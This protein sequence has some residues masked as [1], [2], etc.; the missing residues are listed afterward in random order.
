MDLKERGG[1][2]L[3]E[4]VIFAGIFT[5]T[6]AS[7]LTVLVAMTR[8]QVRQSGAAEV[9][10]QSQF[11]LQT[12]QRYVEQSSLVDL[13]K[14]SATTTL[15]LRMAS[16]SYDPTLI[17]ASGTALWIQE[18]AS[19]PQ[20]LTSPKVN[21]TNLSFVKHENPG[22]H[23]SVSVV[24]TANYNAPN[25]ASNFVQSLS[26]SVA[27][28]SAATFDSNIIP[29]AGNT[30]K[31]G[32]SAGDWQSVNN[33]IIFSGSNVGIGVTP[34]AKFQ[35][36]SGDVYIDT[37]ARGVIQKSADGTCWRLAVSNAGAL[38]AAS[39]TCP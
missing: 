29:S 36:N 3:M 37:V 7:F 4:L 1:F 39:T 16:S 8:V 22:G 14:D 9:N 30:Y 32:A 17:F 25:A 18:G 10:Q 21:I 34:T 38:S 6:V 5:L 19:A 33:T 12:V 15:R 13:V 23:D 27:R 26:T 24:F 20:V 35:V 2:T 28:V 31:L 11:L